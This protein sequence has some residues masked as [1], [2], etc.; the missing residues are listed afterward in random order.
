MRDKTNSEH[1]MSLIVKTV[2]DWM[3]GFI[4]LFGVYVVLYGHETPGGG[5]AGGIVIAGSFILLRLAFGQQLA[6]R[7]SGRLPAAILASAGALMFLGLAVAGMFVGNAFFE[8]FIAP[9]GHSRCGLFSAVFVLL[10]E[11][12]VALVVAMSLFRVFSVLTRGGGRGSNWK[13]REER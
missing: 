12:A 5:F 4:L 11:I 6:L 2:A 8:S 7:R 9:S 13:E 10:C 1:G 3:T